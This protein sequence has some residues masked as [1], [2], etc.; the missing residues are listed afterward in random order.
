[1]QASL[2]LSSADLNLPVPVTANILINHY[3][4]VLGHH[5]FLVKYGG[6]PIFSPNL[7]FYHNGASN[8]F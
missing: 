3:F 6:T 2:G 8:E 4:T 5:P 7:N 1:M